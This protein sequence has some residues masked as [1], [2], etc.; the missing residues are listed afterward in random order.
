MTTGWQSLG[1][2]GGRLLEVKS[3][4]LNIEYND[5]NQKDNFERLIKS[6]PA[7]S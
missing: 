1:T 3:K 7:N 6:L 4:N 2:S 5:I